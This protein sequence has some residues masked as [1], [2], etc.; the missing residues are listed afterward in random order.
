[1]FISLFSLKFKFTSD[2]VL[3]LPNHDKQPPIKTIVARNNIW[4]KVFINFFV[5]SNLMVAR[6]MSQK[7]L[8]CII[9]LLEYQTLICKQLG[10]SRRGRGMFLPLG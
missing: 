8:I 6:R 2:F 5:F 7:I 9:F 10:R 1:M 4:I 3:F